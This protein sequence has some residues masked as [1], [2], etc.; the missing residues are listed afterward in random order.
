MNTEG[1][2]RSPSGDESWV[3]HLDCG[4]EVAVPGASAVPFVMAWLL[5]HQETCEVNRPGPWAQSWWTL[6]RAAGVAYR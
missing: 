6:P 4:H 5:R 2:D 3:V 1:G